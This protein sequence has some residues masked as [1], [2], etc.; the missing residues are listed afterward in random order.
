MEDQVLDVDWS[1]LLASVNRHDV[2][3]TLAWGGGDKIGDPAY[4]QN[5]VKDLDGASIGIVSGADHTLPIAHPCLFAAL[6]AGEPPDSSFA[7]CQPCREH[8]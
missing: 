8:Q 6:V 1:S 3:V 4:A 7:T 2:P 5:L